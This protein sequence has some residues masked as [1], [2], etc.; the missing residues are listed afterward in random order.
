MTMSHGTL[1]NWSAINWKC[2][3]TTRILTLPAQSQDM[4]TIE[5]LWRKTTLEIVKGHPTFKPRL[6]ESLTA[7]WNRG[8][9]HMTRPPRQAVHSIQTLCS[10]AIMSKGWL[11]IY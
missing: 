7:A 6:I 8:V 3:N 2:Q 5:N 11:K 1:L 9:T 4:N 10:K